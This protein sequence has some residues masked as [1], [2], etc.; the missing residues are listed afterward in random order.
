MTT[1]VSFIVDK[2]LK[3]KALERAKREG[4]TLKAFLTYAMK[5]YVE[6]R[7]KFELTVVNERS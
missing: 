2:V 1:Q 6:G 3:N 7:L 5:S 4:V